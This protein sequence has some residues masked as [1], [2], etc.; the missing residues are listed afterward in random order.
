[1][2]F[3]YGLID[4]FTFKVRY[5]G[6]T[7]NLKQRF[8]RQLNEQSKTY[9][10]NWIQ[11]LRSKGKK[12]VQVVLQELNDTDDWQAAEKKWI[13]IA[14]KYGWDLVNGTDGGDGVVNL[15][16]ESRQRIADAWKG[17]KHKPETLLRLSEI[18]KGRVRSESA[19]DIVSL[20]MKGRK[21]EWSDKLQVKLRKFD[22][23]TLEAVLA[24]L[25]TMTVVEVAKKYGVH[26]TTVTKI[27][28]GTY[29]TFKQKTVNYKKPRRY[30]NL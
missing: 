28:M 20:K 10:C 1:M 19:K 14:K 21:I 18:R 23:E 5:I 26:R 16:K 30:E 25:K 4:P 27:K 17:R 15:P 24:D 3:I 7:M 11:S 12:P 8:D 6:K 22:D 29:K 13:A 9:R 2:V